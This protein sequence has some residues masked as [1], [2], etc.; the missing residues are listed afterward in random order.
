MLKLSSLFNKNPSTALY[1]KAWSLLKSVEEAA[2]ADAEE[3]IKRGNEYSAF[4][5]IA[6]VS[7]VWDDEAYA[8]YCKK[9]EAKGA[10]SYKTLL[11]GGGVVIAAA[12]GAAAYFLLRH[13][14]EVEVVGE[15]VEVTDTDTNVE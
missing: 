12:V 2:T 8:E 5:E 4:I 1:E 14:D 7:G 13:T 15:T 10:T 11:I 9:Q 3:R 6:K